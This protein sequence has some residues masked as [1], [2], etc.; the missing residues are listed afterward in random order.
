MEVAIDEEKVLLI[1]LYNANDETDQ[2]NVLENLLVKLEEHDPDGERNHNFGGD[3]NLIFDTILDSS[4]W[5]PTLKKKSLTK[6]MKVI[7]KLY[8]C[9]IFRV[10]KF[11]AFYIS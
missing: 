11:K 2:L 1:N 8:S 9:D 3:F 10:P 4:G 6:I 7:E 5:N